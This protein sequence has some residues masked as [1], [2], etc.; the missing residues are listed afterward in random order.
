MN[1][2]GA[3]ASLGQLGV[4]QDDGKRAATCSAL[5][6]CELLVIHKYNFMRLSDPGDIK[7][8][9][10]K[11]AEI[12]RLLGTPPTSSACTAWL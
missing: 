9:A 11:L 6:D 4:V 1:V 5:T 12:A 7:G 8:I 3:G 10:A 2:L